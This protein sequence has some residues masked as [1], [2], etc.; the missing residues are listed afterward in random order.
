MVYCS[1]SADHIFKL[2]R[3]IILKKFQFFYNIIH[4]IIKQYDFPIKSFYF[5]L[6]C[7]ISNIDGFDFISWGIFALVDVIE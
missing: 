1:H 7:C 5:L 2:T 3:Y 6:N 4:L